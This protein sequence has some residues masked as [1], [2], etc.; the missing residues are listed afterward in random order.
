MSP[1]DTGHVS[2]A[3]RLVNAGGE[4]VGPPP[5]DF[6]RLGLY[7]RAIREHAGSSLADLAAATRI[8]KAYLHAIEHGDMSAL[9]SRPF[10]L[11]YVRAYSK[12][13][14]LDGELAV[15]RFKH[16][17]PEQAEPLRAP[18]GVHLQSVRG[19][20]RTAIAVGAVVVAVLVWNLVQHILTPTETHPQSAKVVEAA[21][22]IPAPPTRNGA[23]TMAAPT[24]PPA[25][26]TTPPPYVTPGLEA[27]IKPMTA[28]AE[29][30]VQGPDELANGARFE[31]HGTMYGVGPNIPAVTLQARRPGLI[32]IRHPD[33][34]VYFAR[35][36]KAGDAFRAPT[37]KGLSIDVVDPTS[38]YVY[39]ENMLVGPLPAPVSAVDKLAVAPPVT[40]PAPAPEQGA[41]APTPASPA[42]R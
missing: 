13:L 2:S 37:G 20:P 21:A 26:S 31:L 41:A 35:Q 38:F 42:P 40:G 28:A 39:A 4:Q 18:V 8:R 9:P 15:A 27:I 6:E 17:F 14:G 7:L 32:V 36:L 24:A 11:G 29:A 10:A 30:E 5:E 19:H 34:Q 3:L 25:E 22:G 33:K 12:A 1:L 23:F 16:E